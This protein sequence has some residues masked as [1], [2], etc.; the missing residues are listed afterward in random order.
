MGFEVPFTPEALADLRWADMAARKPLRSDLAVLKD[1]PTAG[2]VR[3]YGANAYSTTGRNLRVIYRID[4]QRHQ[5][6]ILA[7]TQH[8]PYHQIR[9][10]GLSIVAGPEIARVT[11]ADCW[12]SPRGTVAEF[13][14]LLTARSHAEKWHGPWILL[15]RPSVVQWVLTA[16]HDGRTGAVESAAHDAGWV[17]R[18][19]SWASYAD[20]ATQDLRA[21]VESRHAEAA[22]RRLEALPRFPGSDHGRIDKSVRLLQAATK[23]AHAGERALTWGL[24]TFDL[25]EPTPEGA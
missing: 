21:W 24:A 18:E 16:Y 11:G 10:R 19:L 23:A 7:A 4:Q 15:G 1:D 6:T 25:R 8:E 13:T 22:I 17:L 12:L 14:R 2:A 9:W 20:Q 3:L 5:M